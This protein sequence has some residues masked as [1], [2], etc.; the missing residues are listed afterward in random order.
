MV[1]IKQ[2]VRNTPMDADWDNL[3]S[4]GM[5]IQSNNRLIHESNEIFLSK[6]RKQRSDFILDAQDWGLL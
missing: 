6:R 4:A 5:E 1:K 3:M 2:Q